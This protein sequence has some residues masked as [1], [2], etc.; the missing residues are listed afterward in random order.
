MNGAAAFLRAV[1]DGDV[2][3]VKRL[4]S[5][6]PLLV[7]AT[8]DYLKTQLHWAAE[9]DSIL[10]PPSASEKCGSAGRAGYR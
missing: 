3:A 1:R 4:L 8:D 6:D 2:P 7:G 10:G 9:H 5:D